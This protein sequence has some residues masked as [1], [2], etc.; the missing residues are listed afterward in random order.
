MDTSDYEK[1]LSV[2]K[3]KIKSYPDF[4]KE[5]ILFRFALKIENNK[6]LF[7]KRGHAR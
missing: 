3:D 5:G 7:G 4:P 6:L 2:L 1:T